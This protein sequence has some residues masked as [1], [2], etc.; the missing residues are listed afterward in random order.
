MPAM[1]DGTKER[2]SYLTTGYNCNASTPPV[3][4]SFHK[5]MARERITSFTGTVKYARGGETQ[6]VNQ[7]D[8]PPATSFPAMSAQCISSIQSNELD[9]RPSMP[10]RSARHSPPFC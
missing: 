5:H 10:D 4:H 8:F 1:F 6:L 2:Q 7:Y 3:V 9:E